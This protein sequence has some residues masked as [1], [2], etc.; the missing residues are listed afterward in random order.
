MTQALRRGKKP[1]KGEEFDREPSR[2][3]LAQVFK[4]NSWVE[5]AIAKLVGQLSSSPEQMSNHEA[6]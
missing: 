3:F 4:L 6:D 2:H 5:Y 1:K